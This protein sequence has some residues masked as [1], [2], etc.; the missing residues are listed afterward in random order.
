MTLEEFAKELNLSIKNAKGALHRYN[1]KYDDELKIN[2]VYIDMLRLL[3]PMDKIE[4]DFKGIQ[5]LMTGIKGITM[6]RHIINIDKRFPKI[7]RIERR[8]QRS[9]RLWEKKEV[10]DFIKLGNNDTLRSQIC[11]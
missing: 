1:C 6:L 5:K 8:G 7:K 2:D 9:V 10:I 3:K 4:I 11:S